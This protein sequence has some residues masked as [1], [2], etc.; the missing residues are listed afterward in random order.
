MATQNSWIGV[1][2]HDVII[3]LTIILFWAAWKLTLCLCS[4]SS[5]H[6][7][8]G[9]E[10]AWEAVGGPEEGRYSQQ[11]GSLTLTTHRFIMTHSSF[12]HNSRLHEWEITFLW[13]F[14]PPKFCF[15]DHSALSNS[16]S[17]SHSELTFNWKKKTH[18]PLPPFSSG[19]YGNAE[20]FHSR[21]RL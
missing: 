7:A 10:P 3:N 17:N 4:H 20:T 13:L 21:G 18:F 8:A 2:V 12:T 5:L 1:V 6:P 9:S 11:H 19:I 14:F 16:Q 15:S